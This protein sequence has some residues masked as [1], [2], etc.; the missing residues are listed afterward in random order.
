[1]QQGQ[2]YWENR[3]LGEYAQS[4]K[5]WHAIVPTILVAETPTHEQ[6]TE[7]LR[8]KPEGTVTAPAASRYAMLYCALCDAS[9]AGTK[10]SIFSLRT[11]IA[12]GQPRDIRIKFI[13][14]R[15]CM[16]CITKPASGPGN[17]EL[18][19]MQS[20]AVSQLAVVQCLQEIIEETLW[21]GNSPT[22]FDI[23]KMLYK[24]FIGAHQN[25]L[26][27]M[28]LTEEERVFFRDRCIF[29]RRGEYRGVISK[30]HVL[31]DDWM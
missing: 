19:L 23:W 21:V 8:D 9:V 20:D 16:K 28:G 18:Q 10:N 3:L 14:A 2:E 24:Y 15:I 26:V 13:P 1:M 22:G 27:K 17:T 7:K 29:P 31:R 12:V 30:T 4:A 11:L 25:L 6:I 5:C